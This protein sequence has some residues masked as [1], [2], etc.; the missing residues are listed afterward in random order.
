M[1]T[2]AALAALGKNTSMETGRTSKTRFGGLL[3]AFL[4][5]LLAFQ[6]S[7]AMFPMSAASDAGGIQVVLCG[8]D[9]LQTITLDL[10]DGTADEAPAE[11]AAGKCPFCIVGVAAFLRQRDWAATAAEFQTFRYPLLATV[12]PRAKWQRR[13][14]AIRAPPLTV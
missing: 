7:S 10:S 6:I 5:V 2:I 1:F 9:G 3:S 14:P 8:G 12:P 11:Q 13:T 4:A